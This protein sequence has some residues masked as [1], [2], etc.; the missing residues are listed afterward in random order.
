MQQEGRIEAFD[1]MLFQ[2]NTSIGGC[3]LIRGTAAQIADVR[4]DPEFQRN[5]VNASLIVEDLQLIDGYANEG[6]AQEM[7]M[8]QEAIAS[9]PQRA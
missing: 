3:I 9:I 4:E 7:A 5:I 8:Y 2:P 6:V 1:V